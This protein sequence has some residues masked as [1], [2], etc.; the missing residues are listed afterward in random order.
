MHKPLLPLLAILTLAGCQYMN[1]GRVGVETRPSPTLPPVDTAPFEQAGCTLDEYGSWTC[2]LDSQL[3]ALGCDELHQAPDLL[4]GLDPATPLVECWL[5]PT[6]NPGGGQDPFQAPRLYNRGCMMPV[7]VRYVISREGQ[8]MLV[9][10]QEALQAAFTPIDSP[11]EAL[12]YALAATGLEAYFNL[13]RELGYR[14]FVDNLEDTQV[15]ETSN[16]YEINLYHYQVC[17]CGPHTTSIVSVQVS[18]K[19]EITQAEPVPAYE[20]PAEDGLCVD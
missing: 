2:P 20:D 17:G 3:A 8:F 9:D 15:V 14:Y 6:R 10:D 1:G 16:G 12:S 18:R 19:G 5:Y 4:G 11:E 13:R 7:F